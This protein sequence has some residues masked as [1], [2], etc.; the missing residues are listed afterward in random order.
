MPPYIFLYARVRVC[1][2]MWASGGAS[3]TV[4]LH[5]CASLVTLNTKDGL[6]K[7]LASEIPG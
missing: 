1:V 3:S 4:A 5:V 6:N 2:C 7:L